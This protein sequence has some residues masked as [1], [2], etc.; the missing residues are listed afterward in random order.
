M[1]NNH[2]NLENKIMVLDNHRAHYSKLFSTKARDLGLDLLYLPPTSSFFNPIETIWSIVK[3]KWRKMILKE[4][5][6]KQEVT[7]KWMIKNLN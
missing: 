5:I 6:N 7:R 4:G 1:L 3:K 2:T